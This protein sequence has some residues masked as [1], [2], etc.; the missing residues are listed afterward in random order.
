[1]IDR[2][3]GS[4]TERLLE[5]GLD[6]AAVR[7][8]VI[9]GNLAN[10]DTPYYKRRDVDFAA[11]LKRALGAGEPEVE[12][13]VTHENH[14]KDP[15]SGSQEVR[16]FREAASSQRNDGNGVDIDREVTYMV[17]N[18]ILYQAMASLITKHF[19]MLRT[20]IHEGRR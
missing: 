18:T 10:V 15:L 12:M 8:N 16:I 6:V 7:H 17:E 5:K 14:I 9:S 1:M 20:V 13:L 11:E 4:P 2:I 19:Q 3:I